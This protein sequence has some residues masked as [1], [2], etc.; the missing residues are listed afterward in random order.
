VKKNLLKFAFVVL[1]VLL[2]TST[3]AHALMFAPWPKHTPEVDPSL[4][5]GGITL[6]AGTLAV[7]RARR[8][9]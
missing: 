4:A 7:L 6:L 2:C 8:G 3:V 1:G 5:I 9:K